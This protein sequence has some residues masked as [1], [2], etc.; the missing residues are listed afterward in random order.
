MTKPA[1]AHIVKIA[2]GKVIVQCPYCHHQHQH[3]RFSYGHLEH[4][5]PSC[6]VYAPVNREQRLAGYT[7]QIPAAENKNT[8][9]E[10]R[11]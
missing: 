7:F 4:R 5:A 11:H 8:E 10:S 2:K 9:K 6:G 3:E 1:V